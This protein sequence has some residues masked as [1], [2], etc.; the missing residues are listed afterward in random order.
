MPE[1]GIK[2]GD[3]SIPERRIAGF[4]ESVGELKEGVA[5]PSERDPDATEEQGI[6]DSE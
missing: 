3:I 1:G 4:G 5:Y 6:P 2:W